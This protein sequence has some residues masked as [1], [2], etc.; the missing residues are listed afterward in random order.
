MK[1]LTMLNSYEVILEN[2]EGTLYRHQCMTVTKRDAAVSAI[3]HISDTP[4][5]S[6]SDYVVIDCKNVGVKPDIDF[7]YNKSVHDEQE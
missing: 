5:L 1:D 6:N 4:N 7:K 3:K 2:S